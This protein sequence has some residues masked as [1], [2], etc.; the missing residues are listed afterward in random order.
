MK[1][2]L[3]AFNTE[4]DMIIA[5]VTWK[6]YRISKEKIIKS[7]DFYNKYNQS[8]SISITKRYLDLKIEELYLTFEHQEKKQQEREEQRVIRERIRD[9]ERL[10][11]DMI[12]AE[13]EEEKYKNLLD[14]A[15]EEAS[16][17]TGNKLNE[18]QEK[19]DQLT[20][21]LKEAQEKNQR[22]I[23]MAQQTKSG[24][25]YIISNIGSFGRDV[26]KIGMT[27]R[28]DP[29]DR[30]REL[31]DASV[32]FEFD[33]HAMIPCDDAPQLENKLHSKFEKYKINLINN[34]REF[35]RIPIEVV[36]D[37]LRKELS[38]IDFT[39]E[40]LAEQFYRSED[41]RR[42][43]REQDKSENNANKFPEHI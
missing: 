26:F 38:N 1:L 8:K 13:K 5:N 33:V 12:L 18:L 32:P 16:K 2:T 7:F 43:I 15:K 27:R 25:V 24:Y 11:R 9:E 31:G 42:N 3:M 40:V 34:R 29:Y 14:K 20:N 23:S 35:F 36:E 30:V 39:K 4:C 17:A 28:L 41:I 22:A 10:K 21:L 19:I 6:N 37:E